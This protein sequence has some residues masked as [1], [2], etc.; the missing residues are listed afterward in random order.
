MRFTFSLSR[1][2][3][4]ALLW[5][6]G[7]TTVFAQVTISASAI[8]YTTISSA[9]AAAPVNSTITVAAGTYPE[10]LVINKNLTITGAGA[11]STT[12]KAPNTGLVAT[13]IDSDRYAVVDIKGGAT[14]SISGVTISGTFG[15][16]NGCVPDYYG[17]FVY[18]ISTINLSNVR[19]TA[20]KEQ[21]PSLFG[22]QNGIGILT[23]SSGLAS[24]GNANLTNV[25]IDDYQKG[26]IIVTYIGSSLTANGVTVTGIGDSNVIGQNGIQVSDNATATINNAT[27]TGNSYVTPRAKPSS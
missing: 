8:N 7:S 15:L 27:V 4:F 21:D 22:C 26:G 3:A 6:V 12:I 2:A 9:I 5:L 10:Q 11:S 19:I 23:G 18:E 20:I 14:V 16:A 13:V 25:T 1:L 17:V 24:V